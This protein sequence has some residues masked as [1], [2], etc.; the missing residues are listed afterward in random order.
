MKD[1]GFK[2][3]RKDNIAQHMKRYHGQHTKETSHRE[4]S[5][6]V[7]EVPVD[8]WT[9]RPLMTDLDQDPLLE[10]FDC[11][12]LMRAASAG[13]I[14]LILRALKAGLEVNVTA[15][16]GSTLLHCA[17]RA[18]QAATVQFLLIQGADHSRL[19]QGK[20]ARPIHE[21]VKGQSFESFKL[22]HQAGARM[23]SSGNFDHDHG[24]LIHCI[25]SSGNTQILNYFLEMDM[26][27]FEPKLRMNRLAKAAARCG[28]TSTIET[29]LLHDWSLTELFGKVQSSPLYYAACSGHVDIVRALLLAMSKD[30]NLNSRRAANVVASSIRGS[31]RR[32]KSDVVRAVLELWE[33]D[34]VNIVLKWPG[35]TALHYAAENGHAEAV[36]VLLQHDKIDV[37]SLAYG[38][39]A[40]LHLAARCGHFPV[41]ELLIGHKRINLH[42]LNGPGRTPL[43]QAFLGN[44]LDIVQLLA[45]HGALGPRSDNAGFEV[46]SLVQTAQ[47]LLDA[48]K[49]SLHGQAYEKGGD[50]GKLLH[51][52]ASSGDLDLA[53]LVVSH[54]EFDEQVLAERVWTIY[55]LSTAL[56]VARKQNHQEMIDLLLAHG[57]TDT[58][59]SNDNSPSSSTYVDEPNEPNERSTLDIQ[60]PYD[61][62][63]DS[64]L[65]DQPYSYVDEYMNTNE[66][67]E[68]TSRDTERGG[69][70]SWMDTVLAG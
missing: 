32:G 58:L 35:K 46:Y 30:K 10:N 19:G 45:K 51:L 2:A 65:E 25:A 41:V 66:L 54:E 9:Q 39:D 8:A 14:A 64:G 43:V 31:A 4:V 68:Y 48:N 33:G 53:R 44:N 3:T 16:D 6:S 17:A 63:S 47:L 61:S 13:N 27:D 23:D 37:N 29:I 5:L 22:L 60:D 15:D 62:N 11:S 12:S 67:T 24:L 59:N 56:E 34:V 18:N 49:L 40:A 26:V 52:A 70:Q 36:R 69:I 57:A 50:A 21:A 1:C 38:G 7:D 20:I 55:G 42:A 28:Q